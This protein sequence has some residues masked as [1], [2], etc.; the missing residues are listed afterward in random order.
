VLSMSVRPEVLVF[1]CSAQTVLRLAERNVLSEEEASSIE[2][3]LKRLE[4]MLQLNRT[5]PGVK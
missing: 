5:L 4:A 3:Y 2:E 1:G